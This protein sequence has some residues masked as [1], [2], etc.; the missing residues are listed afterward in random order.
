MTPSGRYLA[1]GSVASLTGYD[2]R[3]G[4]TGRPDE[5]MFVYDADTQRLACASCDPTGAKP[6]GSASIPGGTS[7]GTLRA[8]YLPRNLSEEGRLF[9]DSNDALVPHDTD[10]TQDVYEWEPS[11]VGS[12]ETAA[13]CLGLISGG[14]GA[15]PSSFIDA[16]TSG[17]DV[18]FI[19]SDR[20]VQ[21]DFDDSYDMYDAH[22]CGASAT[23]IATP[24]EQGPCVSTD[25]CRAGPLPS[26]GS[27]GLLRAQRSPARETSRRRRP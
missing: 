7:V 26:R 20:L 19:T 10:G 25:A 8:T 21:Q 23:C 16:S 18:F 9:F 3:D 2:N 12:C 17:D 14:T 13:G 5:E 24:A 11:G 15:N 1:F 4:R 6:V 22:V 27:L